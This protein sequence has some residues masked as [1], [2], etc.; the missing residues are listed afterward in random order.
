MH[1]MREKTQDERDL[2][3]RARSLVPALKARTAQADKDLKVPQESVAELQ[4]AGLLRALQPKAFGGYEVDPRTFFEIQ[5]ILAEGCMSTAWIYGVMGVHPWQLARYPIEAQRE[6]WADDHN[7]LICSTYMPAARVTVVEGGY[8]I[9]GRWGFSSGSEHCQW[10]FLGGILPPDGEL[11]AEHGTFLLPRKDYQIE[12]NWDVMGLRG[13][14]SHDIVVEDVFVPAHRVQRTNNWTLEATPGRRVN[15]NPIYAIPFAQ[16][17]SRAVSTSAIGALQGAINEFRDNAAKHIG[18]HGARTADDPVA[19]TAVAEAMITVDSLRLV[20]ERNYEHLMSLARVGEYPDT[21]TRLLYRYQSAYV[22]N[23][24][25]ERAND[26]L[27]SMAASGLYNTNPVARLFRDLHQ[28]RGHI[29]NNYM[30]YGR[31]YGAV[32]LGLPNPDPYV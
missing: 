7:A 10:V 24:C 17:F 4:S 15:T 29:A 23:I 11:A 32:M 1:S 2:I 19:Q 22:T 6:V 25:A 3:E 20:L 26:L 9:S 13:T 27:R 12:R 30:A 5:T 18:K 14:G 21:E 8:R 28:A 16:V 31:S